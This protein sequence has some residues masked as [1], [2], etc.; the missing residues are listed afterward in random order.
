MLSERYDVHIFENFAD[1][2]MG[3]YRCSIY[4]DD[5]LCAAADVS[6]YLPTDAN[7][8]FNL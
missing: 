7:K 3:S 8:A 6:T 2:E 4:N 5:S 1:A